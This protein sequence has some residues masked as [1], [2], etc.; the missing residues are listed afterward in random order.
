MLIKIDAEGRVT[1][2]TSVLDTLDVGPGDRIEIIEKP[3]G[4]ILRPQRQIDYSSLG[5]LKDKITGDHEPLDIH[6]FREQG[7]DPSLRD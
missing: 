3:D 2:P 4:F 5:T 6:V 7:Y 1:L